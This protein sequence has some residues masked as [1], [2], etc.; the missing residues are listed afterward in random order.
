[1]RRAL[2]DLAVFYTILAR[3][4]ESICYYT[5]LESHARRS[6]KVLVQEILASHEAFVS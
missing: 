1:M 3:N 2:Q 5:A 6:M 4:A